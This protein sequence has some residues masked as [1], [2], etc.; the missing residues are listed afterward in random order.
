MENRYKV[1]LSN[2]NIYKEIELSPELTEMKV[3]TGIDCDVRLRKEFLFGQIELDFVKKDDVWSVLCSDNMYL[4]LGDVRKLMTKQLEHGDEFTVKYQESDNDVFAV[5]FMIDFDN[6]KK[7]YERA[8]SISNCN[9]ISIGVNSSSNIVLSSQYV[10]DDQI[11]LSVTNDGLNMNVKKTAYGVY[12]NG[13]KAE[14]KVTIMDSDF[15]SVSDY[16]FYY[17]EHNIWTEIRKDIVING[18]SFV[19]HPN[20]NSYPMFSRNTRIKAVLSDEK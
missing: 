13:K 9:A 20:K 7:R 6:G 8:I 10:K 16:I 3:G 5:S 12:H 4:S 11:E 15:F 2:K 14:G 1:I 17:K 19:D 18:L